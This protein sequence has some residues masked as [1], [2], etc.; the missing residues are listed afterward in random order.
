M[1]SK[2]FGILRLYSRMKVE[3]RESVTAVP[4]IFMTLFEVGKLP[5]LPGLFF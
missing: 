3:E 1:I 2:H 4:P 5:T